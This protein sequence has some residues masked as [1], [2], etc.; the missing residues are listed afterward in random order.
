MLLPFQIHYCQKLKKK[1]MDPCHLCNL[2]AILPVLDQ[3]FLKHFLLCPWQTLPWLFSYNTGFSFSITFASFSVLLWKQSESKV[4]QACPT[5][6]DPMDC[7]LPH[8]S[9]H[10]IFQARVSEWVAI[11]FSRGPSQP[12]DWTQVSHIVGRCFT[13]WATREDTFLFI[14]NYWRTLW[15]FR[16]FLLLLDSILFK[17]FH[18]FP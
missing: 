5:L 4:T 9:V 10:G 3:S 8:S 13:I 1:L 18:L 12:R 2:L 7:S 15:S 11:S 6:C 17:L 16:I 14:F